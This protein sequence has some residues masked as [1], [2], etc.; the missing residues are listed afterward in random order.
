MQIWNVRCI[1]FVI[2]FVDGE[3]HFDAVAGALEAAEEEI[4]LAGWW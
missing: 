4:F 3:S 1:S 2:R